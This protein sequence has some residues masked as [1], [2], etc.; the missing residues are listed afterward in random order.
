MIGNPNKERAKACFIYSVKDGTMEIA[1]QISQANTGKWAAVCLSTL[2]AKSRT[3]PGSQRSPDDGYV[4]LAADKKKTTK[5][6]TGLTISS[7][8]PSAVCKLGVQPNSLET[9][10]KPSHRRERKHVVYLQMHR[11]CRTGLQQD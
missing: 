7:E 3:G 2:L 6:K 10:K 9:M 1:K 4:K 11:R 5:K 8:L